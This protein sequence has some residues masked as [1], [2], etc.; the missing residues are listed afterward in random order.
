MQLMNAGLPRQR[1]VTLVEL[2]IGL[3]IGLIV[4]AVVGTVFINVIRGSNDTLSSIKL[5]QEVRGLMGFMTADIRRAGYWENAAIASTDPTIASD[6][7]LS[8][9][10]AASGPVTDIWI[11]DGGS[12]L[13]YSYDRD[14]DGDDGYVSD[15]D[16]A[17][18]FGYRLD[19]N[20]R[21]QA[22]IPG[23]LVEEDGETNSCTPGSPPGASNNDAIDFEALT[24]ERI[25]DITGLAFSTE[26]STC[27][28]L[29]QDVDW[30]LGS[31]AT[32]A[33]C[34]DTAPGFTADDDDELLEIRQIRIT[35]TAE[36]RNDDSIKTTLSE[37]VSVRNNRRLTYDA[38]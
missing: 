7:P 18:L 22:T 38:P 26:G 1:G 30:T 27:M 16:P 33:A 25:V 37:T 11:H 14:I 12:C 23:E 10:D 5:N 13:M 4:L 31:G 17:P 34:D 3:L 19:D 21:I 15:G 6:N 8:N 2:M 9:R 20:G 32:M 35:I 24:D 29:T 36:H 28:N